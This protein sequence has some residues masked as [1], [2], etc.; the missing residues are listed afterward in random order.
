MAE[1]DVSFKIFQLHSVGSV[2]DLRLYIH[3]GENLFRRSKGRL[4][5]VEL[6]CQGLYGVEEFIDVHI[7]GD[8]S[9]SGDGLSHKGEVLNIALAA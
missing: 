1:F 5:P 3:D 6:L 2:H 9:P 7:E 8:Q 4:E